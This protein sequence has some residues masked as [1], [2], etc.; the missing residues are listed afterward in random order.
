MLISS[1]NASLPNFKSLFQ[2]VEIP[3]ALK[4]ETG[5]GKKGIG[6]ATIFHNLLLKTGI[7][8]G[9]KKKEEKVQPEAEKHRTIQPKQLKP[10]KG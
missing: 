9:K 10:G 7:S 1:R 4:K 8:R 6:K 3:E 5:G 2:R